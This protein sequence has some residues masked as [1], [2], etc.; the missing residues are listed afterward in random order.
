[1]VCRLA[2][3]LGRHGLTPLAKALSALNLLIFGI[4]VATHCQIKGGL[5]LP[6]TQGTVIGAF[7]IGR[8]ATIFQGVTLGA[9]ELEISFSEAT[10]P[11]IGD[12][13]VIGAG[14]KVLGGIQV[15]SN[16]KI[17]ANA[18]VI[19]PVPDNTLA[20]GVPAIHSALK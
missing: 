13:V 12:G 7:S 20:V 18:V 9:K 8:N 6:H 17:G 16:V 3:S 2:F 10:R 1:L 19:R 11:S 15:G 4:E 5:L 14:A